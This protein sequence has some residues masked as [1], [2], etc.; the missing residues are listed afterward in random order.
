MIQFIFSGDQYADKFHVECMNFW[1]L[2]HKDTELLKS[3]ELQ[4]SLL[5]KLVI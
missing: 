1:S 2:L 4:V 3:D 5:I